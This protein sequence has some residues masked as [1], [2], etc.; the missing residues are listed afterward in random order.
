ML[1]VLLNRN[2]DALQKLITPSMSKKLRIDNLIWFKNLYER[3]GIE[4]SIPFD[5]AVVITVEQDKANRKE[6][7]MD[8]AWI[9]PECLEH[10]HIRLN[11]NDGIL[12]LNF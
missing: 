3:G 6:V 12:I 10:L 11:R 5:D 4:Q 9:P 8:I 1:D 7:T 2:Q